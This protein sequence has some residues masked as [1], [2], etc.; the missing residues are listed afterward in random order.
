MKLM[1][2]SRTIAVIVIIGIL[3]SCAIYANNVLDEMYS[4]AKPRQRMVAVDSAAGEFYRQQV[5]PII[6]KRCVVCHGCYDAP[7]QL[8]LSSAEGIDRGAS[9]AKVYS[10]S[11]LRAA[12]TSRLFIDHDSTAQWRDNGFY[13]VLNER[14]QNPD[15]NQQAS[16]MSRLLTL[17]QQHPLPEGEILADS[18][19]LALN[20]EQQC[21][22]LEELDQF[23]RKFPGCAADKSR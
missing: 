23:E 20:R 9:K 11:R 3:S 16:V 12:T 14:D 5:Q 21:P 15:T 7:C 13:P 4:A 22:K 18:F 17:K 1:S 8:K 19:D 10:G 6:E 2:N